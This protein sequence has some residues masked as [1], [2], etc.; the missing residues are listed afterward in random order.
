MAIDPISG[1]AALSSIAGLTRFIPDANDTAVNRNVFN[2]MLYPKK[3]S[4][5]PEA[6]ANSIQLGT[7][8]VLADA[9]NLARVG[10]IVELATGFSN[11][12]L[13]GINTLTTKMG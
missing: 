8:E 1:L 6:S 12:V 4:E 7:Q 3:V 11:K 13:G 2:K 9:A 10:V 5:A